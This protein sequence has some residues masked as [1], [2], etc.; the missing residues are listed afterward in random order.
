MRVFAAIA[1]SVTLPALAA[2]GE[3]TGDAAGRFTIPAV[4]PGTYPAIA[5]HERLGERTATLT[6]PASGSASLELEYP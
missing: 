2:A 5:W 1:L 3:V 6:V 4:P